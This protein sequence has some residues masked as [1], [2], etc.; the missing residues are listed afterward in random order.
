MNDGESEVN[1]ASPA[2]ALKPSEPLSRERLYEVVWREPMLR[3]AERLG[4]SSSYMA[5]VCT[6]LRV[7]RPQRGYWAQLEV[8]KAPDKPALPPSRP[9]DVVVWSVGGT[10]TTRQPIVARATR[11]AEVSPIPKFRKPAFDKPH[12]LLV[13]VKPF[14]L[15][16]RTNGEDGLLRPFKRLLVDVVVSE[17]TLDSALDFANRLF[18]SL[19]AKGHRVCLAPGN[20]RMRRAEFDVREAAPT[21]HYYPRPWAPDRSTVTYV[22]TLPI[23]LTLFEIAERIEVVYVKGDYIPVRN[24]T[25]D[26]LRRYKEPYHWRTHKYYA[27]GRLCLQAYFPDW[28]APW[29]KQWRESKPGQLATLILQVIREVEGITPDLTTRLAEA[30]KKAEVERIAREEQRQRE[31]EEAERARRIKA[32]QEAR[33]DI[34][35][36]IAGWDQAMRIQAY[37]AAAEGAIGGLSEAEQ[38]L[39]SG[40]L[41]EARVLI[42]AVDPLALLKQWKTPDER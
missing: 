25:A 36:A 34:L 22:G 28:R 20:T 32:R 40:R 9:G 30:E 3:I 10:F 1:E 15:K 19:E 13:G 6:E 2:D 14:F 33:Q 31:R 8:G 42:G 27:S 29:T 12:E 26:Q 21:T 17:A 24:L 37:F 39:V 11:S 7:P 16:T 5:R 35:N 4:V 38:Q 18:Q 41:E 23:G